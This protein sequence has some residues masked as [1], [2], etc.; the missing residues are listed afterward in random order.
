M[1]IIRGKK[2]KFLKEQ[3]ELKETDEPQPGTRGPTAGSI[4]YHV[5][6]IGDHLKKHKLVDTDKG[7]KFGSKTINVS[8]DD[9]MADLTHNYNK[10]EPHLT[11]TQ[12]ELV[13]KALKKTKMPVQYIRNKKLHKQYKVL[14]EP[15]V[16][17]LLQ[18]HAKDVVPP[19]FQQ[20]MPVKR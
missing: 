9:M 5:K 2:R 19:P 14:G 16:P 10:T 20:A 13:L 3:A 4:P 12:Q 1:L 17:Q 8:Y 15:A 6:I 11:N 18:E 7:L